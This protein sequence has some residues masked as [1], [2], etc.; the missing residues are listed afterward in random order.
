MKKTAQ[1]KAWMMLFVFSLFVSACGGGNPDTPVDD[2]RAYAI[3]ALQTMDL[4]VWWQAYRDT[5]PVLLAQ[6]V[7]EAAAKQAD[8]LPTTARKLDRFIKNFIASP[9]KNYMESSEEGQA[10][11]LAQSEARFADPPSALW[12]EEL[13]IA[14]LDYHVLPAEWKS[15]SRLSEGLVD[16]PAIERSP[17]LKPDVIA[18]SLQSL[19]AAYPDA[20]IYQISYQY[21]LGSDL[22]KVLMEFVPD[23]QIVYREGVTL[24]FTKDP[25]PWDDLRNGKIALEELT[26]QQPMEGFSNPDVHEPPNE[27]L[28]LIP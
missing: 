27:L 23:D 28:P 20:N 24:S 14:L 2:P 4:N 16:P 9:Y 17:Y 3:D 18:A 15:I 12:D 26:W 13:G 1:R 10:F 21:H 19:V 22:K 5:D 11:I 25:V 7:D 8:G 6:F